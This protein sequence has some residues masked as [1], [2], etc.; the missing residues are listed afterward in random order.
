[1]ELTPAQLAEQL[2]VP[3]ARVEAWL[4]EG[5]PAT[6]RDDGA[7][8]LEAAAV[9]AWLI[10]S[11]KASIQESGIAAARVARTRHEV[12]HHF[13]VSQRTVADWL[14]DPS[15]PGRAG[16]PGR[17]D[18]YFPLEEI[19][20]W[21]ATRSDKGLEKAG[22]GAPGANA[23]ERLN[24]IKAE[25]EAIKLAQDR[26]QVIDAEETE[27]FLVRTIHAA[28][29]VLEQLADRLDSR[30]PGEVSLELRAAIREVTQQ[31]V[32]QACQQIAELVEGDQDPA[33]DPDGQ[34]RMF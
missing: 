22:E 5:L 13:G 12:A 16:S 27:R 19:A 10:Q 6:T 1:M 32:E 2:A 4:A 33:E 3:V 34:Q 30:L 26:Q 17:Q 29:S 21:W 9:R 28:K 8:V 24:E 20:K 25:R 11:G 14:T 18:G 7:T 23:R 31:T 15:F